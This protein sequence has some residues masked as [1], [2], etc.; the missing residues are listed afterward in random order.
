MNRTERRRVRLVREVEWSWAPDRYMLKATGTLAI[1]FLSFAALIMMVGGIG[2]LLRGEVTTY[3]AIVLMLVGV[4][5]VFLII[6]LI[7]AMCGIRR[8]VSF[9]EEE[10]P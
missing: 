5:V 6:M 7:I 4:A 8:R 2:L 1:V 10:R 3:T 9:V